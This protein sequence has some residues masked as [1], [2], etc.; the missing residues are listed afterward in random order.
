VEGLLALSGL[1]VASAWRSW[2]VKAAALLAYQLQQEANKTP[3][4]L[5][6]F[7]RLPRIASRGVFN[8]TW[9]FQHVHPVT[10][11]L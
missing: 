10:Q 8:V 2:P 3:Q 5:R 9:L 7:I 6:R 11:I 4:K 1:G